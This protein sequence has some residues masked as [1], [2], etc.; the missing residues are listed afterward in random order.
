MS[1]PTF[2]RRSLVVTAAVS[3]VALLASCSS[4]GGPA[5]T[6]VADGC[7][8]VH[9][10]LDTYT[11]GTLTVGV[12]E[13][14]PYTQTSGSDASGL[15]I[16]LVKRMADAEC[17]AVSFVPITYANGVPMISEQKRAD[18]ITGGWYVTEA[19]AEQ[20]G[21]TSPTFYDSMGIVSADG[22]TTVDELEEIGAVG[23]GAGFSWEADMSAVL[24]SDLKVYPGTIEMKQDLASGRIQAALDGYA[25]A[26]AA[27]ADTDLVVEQAAEDDRI[28]ITTE[29]P[30]IAFP[31]AKENTALSDALS[32]L[33]DGYREDGT[34][35][36]LL[37]DYDLP[38][39][40]LIPADVAAGSIR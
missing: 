29:K 1:L 18:I 28:A 12:P 30:T 27:Y 9:E 22:A 7:E 35:A 15:E 24:G 11:D 20:V 6:A 16:D 33:I 17:F 8:P 25:V 13:N 37:A 36:E 4:A 34:L 14:L 3:A 39:D 21:F 26:V 10:G 23:S 38:A 32:E 40:L 31:V 2:L 5:A 19:R